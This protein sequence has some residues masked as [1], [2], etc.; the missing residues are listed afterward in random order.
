MHGEDFEAWLTKLV[1]PLTS[2]SEWRAGRHAGAGVIAPERER[3]RLGR[4]AGWTRTVVAS[5]TG[6]EFVRFKA[7]SNRPQVAVRSSR[8]PASLH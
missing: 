8:S 1:E 6:F 7:D 2:E 5:P 3:P 4:E